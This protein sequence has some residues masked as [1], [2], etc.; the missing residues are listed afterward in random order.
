MGELEEIKFEV[1]EQYENEKGVFT[2]LSIKKNDMVIRWESGEEL[3]TT[4][5]LQTT[6]QARRQ[7]EDLQ[8]KIKA[9]EAKRPPKS[10]KAGGNFIGLQAGDFKTSA[11]RTNWR[12]RAQL[13]GAVTLKIAEPAFKFNS[14]AFSTKS[15]LHWQDVSKRKQDTDGKAAR[16]FVRLD[17]AGL[18]CG[19][20]AYRG[21]DQEGRTSDWQRLSD[22]MAVEKNKALVQSLVEA[23]HL[24]MVGAGGSPCDEMDPSDTYFEI[25]LRMEKDG[26]IGKAKG[27][28]GEFAKLFM[29]MMP[30]Y[31]AAAGG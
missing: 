10:T 14:W 25:S 17:T 26:A 6:I 11:A 8:E 3:Q 1:D 20:L 28:A 5:E 27:I 15:E 24:S 4:V 22:W 7:W 16:F 2:V 30:L 18:S 13:G 9:E 29:A 31:K 23:H 12:G 19:F 21:E